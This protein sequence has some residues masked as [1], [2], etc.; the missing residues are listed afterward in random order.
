MSHF[1]TTKWGT[2]SLLL[3]SSIAGSAPLVLPPYGLHGRWG[4]GWT[5]INKNMDA[6]PHSKK[7]R[8]T[9]QSKADESESEE[10]SSTPESHNFPKFIIIIRTGPKTISDLSPFW[11]QKVKKGKGAYSSSWNSLQNYETPLVNGNGITQCYLP[12][13]RGDRPALALIHLSVKLQLVIC[14]LKLQMPTTVGGCWPSQ[15]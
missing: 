15:I 5:N 2:C 10:S 7:C 9:K 11:I 3:S 13:D 8:T 12:P 1:H 6:D 4:V 14:S